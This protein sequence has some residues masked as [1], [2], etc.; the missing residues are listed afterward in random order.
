MEQLFDV[1]NQIFGI[2]KENILPI[3]IDDVSEKLNSGVVMPTGCEFK[4]ESGSYVLVVKTCDGVDNRHVEVEYNDNNNTVRITTNY[5]QTDS[6]GN[7]GYH[8]Y[9]EKVLPKDADPDTLVANVVNGLVTIIVDKLPL[10]DGSQPEK[11]TT[12]IKIKR[13]KN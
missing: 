13:L 8:G 3:K 7:Y 4:E 10:P 5:S 6:N 2:N 11:D 1:F 12:S 9:I